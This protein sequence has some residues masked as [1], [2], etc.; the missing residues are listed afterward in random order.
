MSLSPKLD[1]RNKQVRAEVPD[2]QDPEVR[3]WVVVLLCEVLLL[4]VQC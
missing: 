1:L 4:E 3:P 2:L